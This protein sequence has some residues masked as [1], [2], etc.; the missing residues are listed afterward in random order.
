[1]RQFGDFGVPKNRH[2]VFIYSRA[3]HLLGM[4]V[5]MLR[6]LKS[7][8]GPL[9]SGFVVLFLMGVRGTAMSVGGTLVQLGGSL[10]ILEVR[11]IVITLRHL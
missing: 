9:L 8:P 2:A 10:V 4:L 6:M 7:L 1:M 5:S 3:V 11:S